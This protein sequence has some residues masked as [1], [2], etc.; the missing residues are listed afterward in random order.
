MSYDWGPHFVEWVG[1]G[2]NPEAGDGVVFVPGIAFSVEGDHLAFRMGASSAT[3]DYLDE[4]DL[5]P[6]VGAQLAI[7]LGKH[8]EKPAAPSEF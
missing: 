2:V 6:Y 1:T 3:V 7:R 8:P 5:L 4:V